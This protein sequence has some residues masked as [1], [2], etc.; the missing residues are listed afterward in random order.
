MSGKSC[1]CATNDRLSR[2]QAIRSLVGSSLILPG[3]VAELLAAEEQRKT[4]PDPLAA[5]SP[6]FRG[7]A[8]RVIFI[9]L[10]GGFSHVD[11]FD[12]KPKLI[13][14]ASSGKTA[15]DDRTLLGTIWPYKP[16]GQAGIEMTDLFPN[17]AACA[18]DLRLIRSMHGDHNDHVQATLGIHTGSVTFKRPSIGSWVT[19]GLGTENANLPAFV[20]LAPQ[21]PYGGSQVWSSDFLPGAYSATRVASGPEPVP[22]LAPRSSIQKLELGLL[23][24]FNRRHAAANPG[25]PALE[26]RIRSFE[27]AFRMQMAMPDIF[28]ISRESDATLRLYGLARGATEGFGWQCLMARRMIERGVRFVELMDV[29]SSENWDAHGDMETHKPLAVNVDQAVA[30]LLTD[31]KFRGLLQETLVVFTTEFGRSPFAEGTS[32]RSHYEKAYSSWL[33]GGGV[34]PGIVYGKTDE[35]GGSIEENGVHVHD[36]HATIL[37]CLGLD[38]T[39]L[40]YRHAGRDFRLT[41]VHGRVVEEILA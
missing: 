15:F 19:Y 9:V 24:R 27:T 37:H 7:T 8:K 20:V 17:I 26:A 41:D 25:N 39:K 31:L 23:E 21:I 32:G 2:R 36:F 30:G 13:E 28:D 6:H 4:S 35:L 11:S 40:T 34:K 12:P 3:I 14:Y 22:N 33:A 16:Y 18:D 38:H 10:P 1:G 29:G 5:K